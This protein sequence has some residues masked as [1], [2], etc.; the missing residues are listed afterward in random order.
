M[1]NILLIII[2]III[3]IMEVETEFWKRFDFQ[4]RASFASTFAITTGLTPYDPEP[5]GMCV[6][7]CVCV[8]GCRPSL[9][10]VTTL[11]SELPA[12]ESP[13]PGYVTP[14]PLT[15]EDTREF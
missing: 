9:Q 8:C 5:P 11:S 3:I 10:S 2:I 13:C 14:D 6:C 7:V 1:F 15:D 4:L 12:D